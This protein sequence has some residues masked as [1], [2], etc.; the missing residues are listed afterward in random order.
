MIRNRVICAIAFVLA[1]L[2]VITTNSAAAL[3]LVFF[4][5]AAPLASV[6]VGG[7]V[8]ASTKVAFNLAPSCVAG[9]LLEMEISV[10]RP[11]IMRS[12]IELVFEHRNALTGE[13]SKLPVNLAPGSDKVDSYRFAVPTLTCGRV[14]LRVASA[15]VVDPLGF[16][17]PHVR[18]A[19]FESSYTVYPQL[20]D[21][22]IDAANAAHS[23]FTGT[24][25]DHH[26]RGQDKS[27]VFE[28]RGFRDGDSLKSVHWKV[29]ARF[30]ELVVREASH[31]MD[32]DITLLSGAHALDGTR[33]EAVEVMN[34]CMAMTAS[35]SLALVRKGLGHA[36]ALV[37]PEGLQDHY[38]DSMASFEAMLDVLM[39]VPLIGRGNVSDA[40]ADAA[41]MEAFSRIE[42]V[43]K[44]VL[45]CDLV[46]EVLTAKIAD[47]TNLTVVHISKD[48]TT[49]MENVGSYLLAHIPAADVYTRVKNL[50]L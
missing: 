38:V 32:Y 35:L 40:E 15:R 17:A 20:V 36:V 30:D 19:L 26:R 48:G 23:S 34:A 12:Q 11:P 43:S 50:E 31:P 16:C 8:G 21:F 49:G 28:M 10:T 9:Q 25:Y 1:V 41:F 4:V 45:V 7:F 13:V 29:S 14:S 2:L 27:E 33:A 39:T 18:G 3:A 37:G 46:E 6:I 42:R 22:E 47:T 44:T 24:A 5:V